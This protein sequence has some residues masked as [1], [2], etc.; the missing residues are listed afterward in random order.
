MWSIQRQKAPVCSPAETQL[1]LPDCLR[2]FKDGQT[3]EWPHYGF[4]ATVLSVLG[5]QSNALS[6][7]TVQMAFFDLS[8]LFLTLQI[9]LNL[10]KGTSADLNG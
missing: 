9:M 6:S 2:L 10:P 3:S 7:G 1:L 8:I 5:C 4:V